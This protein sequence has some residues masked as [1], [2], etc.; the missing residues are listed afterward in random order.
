MAVGVGPDPGETD[1][2]PG[3]GD[4]LRVSGDRIRRTRAGYNFRGI[5]NVSCP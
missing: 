1:L 5:K 3:K 4:G 2:W